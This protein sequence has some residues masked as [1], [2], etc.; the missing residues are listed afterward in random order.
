MKHVER[1]TPVPKCLLMKKPQPKK[2]LDKDLAK[3]MGKKTPMREA[4]KR[5][6]AMRADDW[7]QSRTRLKD[8]EKKTTD[9]TDA[10]CSPS[11]HSPRSIESHWFE[12]W[13][14]AQARHHE[15]WLPDLEA[16]RTS[17]REC[18]LRE[19]HM[20]SQRRQTRPRLKRKTRTPRRSERDKRSVELRIWTR[21]RRALTPS[22]SQVLS[23]PTESVQS[24]WSA[25][26]RPQ[27]D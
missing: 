4:I 3:R 10:M 11:F 20:C 9:K 19:R 24:K 26:R 5:T 18:G 17:L 14:T 27:N 8:K 16:G 15:Y 22:S 12:L 1:M 6:L 21:S 25:E 2:G 23:T 7:G 13:C